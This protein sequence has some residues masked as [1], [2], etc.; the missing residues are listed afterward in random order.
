MR[1]NGT[2]RVG[3][4]QLRVSGPPSKGPVVDESDARL[5]LDDDGAIIERSW[6]DPEVFAVL[7]QRH[8]DSISRYAARRVGQQAAEDVVA[9]TF[10]TAFRRRDSYDLARSDARPWLDGMAANMVRRHHRAEARRLRAL[11]RTGFDVDTESAA[12]LAEVRLAA[13]E[14]SRVAGALASMKP[15]QREAML[16][17]AW[18]GLTYDQA[19]EALGVPT[20]TIRSRMNRARS[21]VRAALASTRSRE[22]EIS[23]EISHA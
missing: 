6:R 20:G 13:D 15:Q 10:L 1:D 2:W 23:K 14:D 21:H 16:L 4:G 18:A 8:A 9:E 7:F 19:A 3:C 11:E 12:E 17:V 5:H 22:R